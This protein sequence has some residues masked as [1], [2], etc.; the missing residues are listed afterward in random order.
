MI[1]YNELEFGVCH[2]GPKERFNDCMKAVRSDNLE[3]GQHWEE[4]AQNRNAWWQIVN[5]ANINKKVLGSKKLQ[6]Y[7]KR[8]CNIRMEV[9]DWIHGKTGLF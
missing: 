5:F 9:C 1:Y 6:I 8:I 2:R 4:L 3:V 7:K